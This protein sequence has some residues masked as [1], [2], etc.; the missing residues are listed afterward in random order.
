MNGREFEKYWIWTG[1][2]FGPLYLFGIVSLPDVGLD[3]LSIFFGGLL[4]VASILPSIQHYENIKFIKQSG[5]YEDL[6]SYIKLPLKLSFSLI[7][8]E[9]LSKA[10]TISKDIMFYDIFTKAFIVIVLSLWGVFLLSLFRLLM[11]V[12]KLLKG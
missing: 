7:A 11:L 12:P 4:V 10:L 8:L 3:V 2:L 9:F 5:H 6:I 1:L